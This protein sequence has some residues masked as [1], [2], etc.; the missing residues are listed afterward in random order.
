MNC[1]TAKA[2]NDI[3]YG[4]PNIYSLKAGIR[5]ITQLYHKVELEK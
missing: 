2:Y 4:S 1:G 3:V 5:E